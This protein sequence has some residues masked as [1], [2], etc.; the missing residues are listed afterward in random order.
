MNMKKLITLLLLIIMTLSLAA[1]GD[2][3]S[4][5]GSADAAADTEV[6]E[7][8]ADDLNAAESDGDI[9]IVYFSAA[10]MTDTDANTGATPMADGT[11]TTGWIANV[12]SQETGGEVV[13][14]TPTTAYP[15][16]YEECADFAKNEADNDVRPE[17][18]TLDI[19]PQSYKTIFVGYPIWWYRMPM[20]METF[21]DTYDFTGAT[22]VPF[23]THAG[24]RDGGTYD[25]IR[26]RE[27]GAKVLE[28]LAIS[29]SQAGSDSAE[30]EIR[31][32]LD[33]LDIQ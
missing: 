32:W 12:I 10:N 27:P 25:M 23:N 33:G 8:T 16:D 2:G 26:D 14:L 29:G 17:F 28:G 3:A 1:C 30:Q 19:D 13:A 22:I 5:D 21:F 9:L 15:L 6:S 4:E 11:G 24:S 31:D 7:E 20:I 18:E